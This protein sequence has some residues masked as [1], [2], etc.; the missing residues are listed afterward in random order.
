MANR[1]AAEKKQW[2][3]KGECMWASFTK[4][5]RRDGENKTKEQ[6]QPI[7]KPHKKLSLNKMLLNI[8]RKKT[9]NRETNL[10]S[11]F[12]HKLRWKFAR[13]IHIQED[14]MWGTD[15]IIFP[16]NEMDLR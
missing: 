11:T 14:S 16:Q 3:K 13:N 8:E 2:N 12:Y 15:K 6:T 10:L 1:T 9:Y 4:D 5:R 7:F